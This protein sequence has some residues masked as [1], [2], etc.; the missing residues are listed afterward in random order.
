MGKFANYLVLMSGLTILFYF[1]GLIDQ[2]A[3]STLLNLL[4]DPSSFQDTTLALKAIIAIEAI[5]ASAIVVGFAIAGNIEL[6]VMS[7]FSIFLFNLLWDFTAVFSA[8]SA[9]NP[10]IAI[11]FFAPGIFLFIVTI[12]EWWRGVTT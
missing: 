7:S 5:L 8:V 9:A 10:V 2:T 11:I 3:N 12:L 4:L 1:A 6:G